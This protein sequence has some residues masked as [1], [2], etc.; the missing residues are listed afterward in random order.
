[1]KF[2][3]TPAVAQGLNGN[4]TTR[5]APVDKLNVRFGVKSMKP[6]FR[7]AS[8]GKALPNGHAKKFDRIYTVSFSKKADP[9]VVAGEYSKLPEVEYAEPDYIRHTF[10]TDPNDPYWLSNNSWAQN[11]RDQWDMEI[12]KCPE[13]WDLTT[14][15]RASSSR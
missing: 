8:H 7:R 15:A 11:Y 10:R 13:A 5:I 14:G 2:A 4:V 6:V 12:M 3:S 9:R 1:M